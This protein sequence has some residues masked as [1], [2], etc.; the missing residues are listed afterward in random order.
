MQPLAGA[1]EGRDQLVVAELVERGV[2]LAA[3]LGAGD[4]IEQRCDH[5]AG[6]A[7]RAAHALLGDRREQARLGGW[8]P[9]ADETRWVEIRPRLKKA[10][11]GPTVGPISTSFETTKATVIAFRLPGLPS[12]GHLVAKA[13]LAGLLGD[14][15][16]V[17]SF[18]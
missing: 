15:T 18:Q 16:R 13:A 10:R 3:R 7:E 6:E 8:P 4:E 9:S 12:S 2:E 1:L 11:I 5:V 17:G 14:Q